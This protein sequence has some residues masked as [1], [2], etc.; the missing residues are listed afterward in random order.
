MSYYFD[1]LPVHPKPG[2][3]VSLTSYLTR[4]AEANEIHQP[5]W[6]FSLVQGDAARGKRTDIRRLVDNPPQALAAIATTISCTEEELFATT[7]HHL[8]RK[9]GRPTLPISISQFLAG[10]VAKHLRYCA[11]CL[12]ERPYYSLLWRFSIL[13]GC[14]DH[15]NQLLELCEHCGHSIPLFALLLKIGTCPACRGDLRSCHA[16]SLS[17][18]ELQAVRTRARDLAFLL[19]PQD[20]EARSDTI[21]KD[22]G[23]C[24]AEMR[25]RNTK[26]AAQRFAVEIGVKHADVI[27]I[28]RRNVKKF[29]AKFQAYVRYADYFGVHCRMPLLHL[30]YLQ[31]EIA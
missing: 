13:P 15:K 6:L 20:F 11:S 14:A 19:S 28:E 21:V 23:R 27:G 8:A 12:A 5:A 18:K 9:F 24:F 4:V 25:R 31:A 26:F 2:Q 17:R 22:V 10:S 3:L 16:Q 30:P 29:A 1:T 7:F